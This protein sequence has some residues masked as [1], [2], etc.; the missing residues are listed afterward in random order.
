MQRF[1][2]RYTESKQA[3]ETITLLLARSFRVA[4]GDLKLKA[5]F[6]AQPS[7]HRVYSLCRPSDFSSIRN[8]RAEVRGV[9]GKV[10]G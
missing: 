2:P 6:L 4:Q 10:H 9:R 3:E 1:L 5:N 7:R 8:Q